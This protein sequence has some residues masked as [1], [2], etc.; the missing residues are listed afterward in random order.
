MNEGR[1]NPPASLLPSLS[2][3][4]PCRN[5]AGN[6]ATTLRDVLTHASPIT[7]RLEVIVVDDAST[8]ATSQA[9]QS[10]TDAR[11]RIVRRDQC[12]GYGAALRSGFAITT[13]DTIFYTDGDGQIDLSNLS[14][15]P[16]LLATADIVIGHRLNRA[17][18]TGRRCNALA[19]TT[20]VNLVFGLRTRDVDCA[21]KAFPASFIR[22]TPLVSNGALISAELLARAK[23]ANLRTA[24]IGVAHRPRNA[25][26]PTGANPRVI[27]RA[28]LELFAL[29]GRIRRGQ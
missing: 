29:A 11:I 9:A 17:E 3:V 5:E 10:I 6:I 14:Q 8:D 27:A 26:K 28:F 23:C 21:F 12:R 25:G 1:P 19:W 2:V 15:L 24:T 22:S 7:H 13:A 4:L 16:H 18:G 20:L